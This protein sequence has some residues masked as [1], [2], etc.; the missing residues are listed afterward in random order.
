MPKISKPFGKVVALAA[1]SLAACGAGD[2]LRQP[3][4]SDATPVVAV[5]STPSTA[6]RLQAGELVA[7][8]TALEADLSGDPDRLDA[9]NDLAVSYC[10]DGH[11][12]AARRLFDAA[13]AE[14]DARVQQ[15]ALVNLGELYALEGYLSAAVA[16]LETAR[17]IDP[18]RPAPHY[19]LALLADGR[20][21]FEGAS[22]ALREAL[23]LDPDGAARE[24][25][26]AVQPEEALH[27]AAPRRP[28]RRR[29]RPR[30]AAPPRAGARPVPRAG[31]CGRASPRGALTRPGPCRAASWTGASATSSA[32]SSRITSGPASRWRASRSSRATTWSARRRPSAA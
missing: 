17:S 13:V 26:V 28:E 16:H 4:A 20:G 14:G 30:R 11:V 12:D 9:L 24:A 1:L 29:S 7:A 3:G 2:E 19:A 23:R 6:S 18:G 27:L 8:R 5:V 15:A 10:L 32:P 25:L 22:A 21:D 31:R